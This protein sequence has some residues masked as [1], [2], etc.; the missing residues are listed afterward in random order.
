M[1]MMEVESV[2]AR[3]LRTVR[4]RLSS[5]AEGPFKIRRLTARFTFKLLARLLY[6]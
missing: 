1:Q 4:A 3:R 6:E 5:A 2:K